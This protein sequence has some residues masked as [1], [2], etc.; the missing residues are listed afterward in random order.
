MWKYNTAAITDLSK[1]YK[2]SQELW[3]LSDFFQVR[4]QWSN[5]VYFC[6][7]PAPLRAAAN[8]KETQTCKKADLRKKF[9][10]PMKT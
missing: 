6:S 9:N 5:V 8:E 10:Q 3:Q 7:V 2:F 1:E 4:L